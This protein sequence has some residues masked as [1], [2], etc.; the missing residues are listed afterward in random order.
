[1]CACV[2]G[3]APVRGEAQHLESCHHGKSGAR[4]RPACPVRD[5]APPAMRSAPV[6][7]SVL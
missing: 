7:S 6:L 5:S 2:Q 3:G 1:M 4:K